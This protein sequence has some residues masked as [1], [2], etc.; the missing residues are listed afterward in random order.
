M[1]KEISASMMNQQVSRKISHRT[2]GSITLEKSGL[3]STDPAKELLT[4]GVQDE[5][6]RLGSKNDSKVHSNLN[7]TKKSTKSKSQKKND[8]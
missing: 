2:Q 6:L 7:S 8:L 5:N 3:D 4:S 1:S